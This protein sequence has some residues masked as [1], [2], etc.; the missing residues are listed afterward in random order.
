MIL[1]ANI[2]RIVGDNSRKISKTVNK[3]ADE[4]YIEKTLNNLNPALRNIF[5]EFHDAA[6]K[7]VV[8][9]NTIFV[10]YSYKIQVA[11]ISK[12]IS[13]NWCANKV[14]P[15][16][17]KILEMALFLSKHL[18]DINSKIIILTI[19]AYIVQQLNSDF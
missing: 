5:N 9:E 19:G 13:G 7:L 4:S 1:W 17:G 18:N 8:I 10:P 6:K 16:Q 15:G 14:A 3:K 2:N 11:A 12:L